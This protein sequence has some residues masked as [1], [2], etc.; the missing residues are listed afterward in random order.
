LSLSAAAAAEL[1]VRRRRVPVLSRPQW[2][3]LNCLA[4]QDEPLESVYSA[5]S[6]D[7]SQDPAQLLAILFALSEMGF[8]VFRQEPIRALGQELASR[9]INPATPADIVGDC[10]EAFE[11]FRMKR[12]YLARLKLGGGPY[13]SPAGVPFGIWVEMTPVGRA[14]W[15]RPEYAVYWDK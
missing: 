15:D 7:R 1:I 3:I 14:E 13:A 10:A 5:F 2:L 8:V 11:E 9:A 6:E 12:D 4:D